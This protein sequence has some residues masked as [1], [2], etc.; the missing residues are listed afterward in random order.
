MRKKEKEK[1]R[2]R[3]RVEEEEGRQKSGGVAVECTHYGYI[4]AGRDTDGSITS[5]RSHALHLGSVEE[6][7]GLYWREGGDSVS[8]GGLKPTRFCGE[9]ERSGVL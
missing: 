2:G 9:R 8:G 5:L 1:G 4:V 6:V 3:K 7:A